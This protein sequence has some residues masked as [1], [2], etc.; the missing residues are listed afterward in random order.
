MN[1][2]LQIRKTFV[3]L[4]SV[5]LLSYGFAQTAED[6]V[7]PI[8]SALQNKEFEQALALLRRALQASPGN[9]QLW[10]M[11]GVAYAGEGKN[12]EAL[13]SFH[14]ALKISPD[15]LPA[16]KGAIQ[17][18]YESGSPAAIPLL[19][20]VL[21]VQPGDSTSHAMLAV[22]EYQQGNVEETRHWCGRPPPRAP[23]WR[24]VR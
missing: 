13:A 5:L 1:G 10:A 14:N 20:R 7:G 2:M 12:Q 17:I 23:Q 21:R 16:L 22:L 3:I 19:Q 15:Y 11:Q 6:R 24:S 4:V 9:A 18:E 8:A